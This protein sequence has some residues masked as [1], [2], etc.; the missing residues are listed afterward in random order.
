MR[1]Q[2][3]EAM[4]VTFSRNERKVPVD[5]QIDA[6]LREMRLV[7]VDSD[8]YPKL[9]AYL[10]RLTRMKEKERRNPVGKDTIVTVIGNLLGILL[11]VAY[12]QK[13]VL[14]SRALTQVIRP[15]S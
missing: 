1:L 13:H 14:T 9:M 4:F 11:I 2:K 7:G 6:V 12:E 15:K 8:Q 10:E 3:G 5:D